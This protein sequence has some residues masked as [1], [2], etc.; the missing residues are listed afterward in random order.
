[1]VGF[2][3]G[4]WGRGSQQARYLPG[5]PCCLGLC[6]GRSCRCVERGHRTRGSAAWTRGWRG[7]ISRRAGRQAGP[8]DLWKDGVLSNFQIERGGAVH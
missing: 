4:G 6:G 8:R 1:M 2:K 5:G 3:P 7:G